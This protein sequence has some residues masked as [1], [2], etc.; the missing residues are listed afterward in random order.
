MNRPFYFTF[1][2]INALGNECV[3]KYLYRAI[4]VLC[5]C[6]WFISCN[7]KDD[8]DLLVV[9]VDTNQDYS[10]PLS[11]IAYEVS[12][13]ELE[14]TDE[15]LIKNIKRVVYN[16][17][18]IIVSETDK[19]MLFDST[20]KF[21]RQ[22]GSKGNGPGEF[23]FLRDISVDIEKKHI[24]AVSFDKIICYDF[25]G[26]LIKE[27]KLIPYR[28]IDYLNYINGD[29]LF[30]QRSLGVPDGNVFSNQSILYRMNNDWQ[31]TDSVSIWQFQANQNRPFFLDMK[32]FISNYDKNTYLYY[33]EFTSESMFDTLYYLNGFQLEPHLKL[34]FNKRLNISDKGLK[35]IMI[36]NIFRNS[37][38]VFSNY[39]IE[40]KT[41]HCFCYDT[42]TG[43]GYNMKDGY[44]DDINKISDRVNIRLH[45]SDAG[46]F[47]YLYTHMED[48]DL[49]EPN[50]TLYIGTFKK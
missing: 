15:S 26:N 35:T 2:N 47:Y 29:I 20:G 30:I 44:T 37:R 41:Y 13:I 8:K 14:L 3:I 24:L 6:F 38:F 22:I 21:I 45:N 5:V 18:Y 28:D 12:A 34:E 48:T 36:I 31:I 33:H 42:K 46:K 11:E 49:E 43:K 23:N 40:N 19:I 17:D 16:D 4:F 10:L 39:L 32:D 50:P 1:L 27:E 25:E 9:Q 7:N